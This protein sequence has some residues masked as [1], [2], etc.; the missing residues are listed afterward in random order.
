LIIGKLDMGKMPP[1]DLVREA[2]SGE[3]G[4]YQPADIGLHCGLLS[5]ESP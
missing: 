5:E 1:P 3:N 2:E 4:I